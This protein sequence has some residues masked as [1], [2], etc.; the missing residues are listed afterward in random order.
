MRPLCHKC[1]KK[2]ADIVENKQFWCA[3]CMIIFKR[4]PI[5]D[6]ELTKPLKAKYSKS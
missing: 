6:D 5:K 1:N 3:P 2:P 4:I